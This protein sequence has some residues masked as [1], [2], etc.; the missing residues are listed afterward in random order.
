MSLTR[1][2]LDRRTKL[3]ATAEVCQQLMDQHGS[4][5]A[6]GAALG[7]EESVVRRRMERFGIKSPVS[8][9]GLQR[10]REEFLGEFPDALELGTFDFPKFDQQR[11]EIADLFLSLLDFDGIR[12]PIFADLH[13]PE[14]H[15]GAVKWA[16]ESEIETGRERPLA[17]ILGDLFRVS[18]FSTFKDREDDFER[19]L[20]PAWIYLKELCGLYRHVVWLPGNHEKRWQ[21]YLQRNLSGNAIK[22]LQEFVHLAAL[23][24]HQVPPEC[25]NLIVIDDFWATLG[26]CVVCH[27]GEFS[28]IHGRSANNCIDFFDTRVEGFN[29]LVQAHTHWQTNHPYRLRQAYET[30]CL[31]YEADYSRQDRLGAGKKDRWYLGYT[32]LEFDRYGRIDF[33]QSRS[34]RYP[35]VEEWWTCKTLQVVGG[36][37]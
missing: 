5:R 18:A 27:A 30:G 12:V 28:Q 6:T 21:R 11:E 17:I 34:Y 10:Q 9:K 31:C 16:M 23:V 36:S 4:W 22:L 32:A 20:T 15:K 7:L 19:E 33:N 37:K 2:E 3:F 29:A 1:Q 26:D 35:F 24:Q 8:N 13:I 25:D 14:H